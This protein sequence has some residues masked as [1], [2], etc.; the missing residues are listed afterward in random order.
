MEIINLEDFSKIL[1]AIDDKRDKTL[2]SYNENREVARELFTELS[3]N[4]NLWSEE[5]GKWVA[6]ILTVY[7]MIE[8]DKKNL[9]LHMSSIHQDEQTVLVLLEK[10]L[11]KR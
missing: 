5:Y 6:K 2:D 10:Y 1:D 11:W 3:Q 9:H 8:S 7:E 4:L